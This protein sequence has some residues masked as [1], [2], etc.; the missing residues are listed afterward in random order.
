[1]PKDGEVYLSSDRE[2]I[3]LEMY[4]RFRDNENFEP[5]YVEEPGEDK[6]V[7]L[8][9]NPFGIPTERELVCK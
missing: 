1:M 2:E 3:A 7:W 8:E 9:K 6:M 4:H 5:Y